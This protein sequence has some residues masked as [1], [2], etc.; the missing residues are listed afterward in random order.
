MVN[1][2]LSQQC[3]IRLNFIQLVLKCQPVTRE[4]IS[5]DRNVIWVL[6]CNEYRNHWDLTNA[7]LICLEFAVDLPDVCS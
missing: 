7:S 1:A 2:L 6:K 3:L 5:S 4:F